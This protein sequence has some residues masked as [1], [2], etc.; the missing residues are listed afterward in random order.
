[1]LKPPGQYGAGGG[2]NGA[3]LGR[4]L[5]YGQAGPPFVAPR[6]RPIFGA[7]PIATPLVSGNQWDQ[8][9]GLNQYGTLAG[10][11]NQRGSIQT[12]GD[13]YSN[14]YNFG[15]LSRM[16]SAAASVRGG[17]FGGYRQQ[18]G[19]GYGDSGVP[20]SDALRKLLMARM[21]GM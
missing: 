12:T 7:N 11:H 4:L 2:L 3:W 1:M 9:K 19:S 16:S 13:P 20:T 21:G 5:G 14:P 18:A 10:A 17:S 6:R 8:L 15:N